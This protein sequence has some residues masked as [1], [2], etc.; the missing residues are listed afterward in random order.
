M[1][2][3]ML[4]KRLSGDFFWATTPNRDVWLCAK[5]KQMISRKNLAQ[6]SHGMHAEVVGSVV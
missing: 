1:Q 5:H 6:D 3:T 2:R 4:Q